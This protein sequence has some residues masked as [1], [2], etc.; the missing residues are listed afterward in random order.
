MV[1][2]FH[3]IVPIAVTYTTNKFYFSFLD[4]FDECTVEQVTNGH[5]NEII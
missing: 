3:F 4:F 1:Y 5:T 2:M